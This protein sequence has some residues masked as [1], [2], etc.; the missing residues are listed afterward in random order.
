M[1]PGP[2]LTPADEEAVSR[3][4]PP[5]TVEQVLAWA[6]AYRARTGRWPA[7][8]SGPVPKA[9]GETWA[10]IDQA[11]RGGGRGLPGGYSLA[12][13]LAL[14]RDAGPPGP[15]GRARVW[16]AEEDAWVRALP[17]REA[18]RRVGCSVAAVYSRRRL[19]G[20]RPGH[21]RRR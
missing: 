20:I 7:A 12:R 9:P 15:G 2:R 4:R 16:T 11:L 13:L 3:T 19:L 21:R 8:G 14:L 17:A 10:G 1:G 6:D 5:L 18:A